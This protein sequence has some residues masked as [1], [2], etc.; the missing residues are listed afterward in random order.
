M[1]RLPLQSALI[2]LLA[3][4]LA[5]QARADEDPN[6]KQVKQLYKKIAS[7]VLGEKDAKNITGQPTNLLILATPGIPVAQF[8]K[9]SDEDLDLLYQL[10]DVV[11]KAN[12]HFIPNGEWRYSSIFKKI[13]EYKQMLPN[14]PEMLTEAED[15]RLKAARAALNPDADGNII[16]AYNKYLAP[17]QAAVET[18]DAATKNGKTPGT[19][20]QQAKA[21]ALKDL[22]TLGFKNDVETYRQTIQ[23]LTSKNGAPWWQSLSDRLTNAE[24][25]D[26][27]QAS[28]FPPPDTWYNADS[29]DWMEVTYKTSEGRDESQEKTSKINAE[30]EGSYDAVSVKMAFKKEDRNLDSLLSQADTEI[31]FKLKRVIIFRKWMDE[32]VFLN[33]NY[34]LPKSLDN[35]VMSYGN[36]R[37]NARNEPPMPV[38]VK[39]LFLVKDLVIKAKLDQ[40]L[41]SEWDKL[42]A[43][44]ARVTVGPITVSGGYSTSDKGHRANAYLTEAG[45]NTPGVQILAF[46]ATVPPRFPNPDKKYGNLQ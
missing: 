22:Q 10:A 3:A 13:I 19:A 37:D 43:A 33:R 1:S 45:I 12:P 24:R 30:V 18:F 41:R 4:G 26:S 27:Y 46:L 20:I 28:F 25:G 31:S 2:C 9:T 17:Y 39:S 5:P 21:N 15:A 40:K 42:I 7:I 32:D 14:P 23:Q 6:A 8:D 36:F 11:P 16:N 34:Y 29:K 35:G 38:Y 44:N